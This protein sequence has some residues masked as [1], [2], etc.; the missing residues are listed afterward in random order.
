MSGIFHLGVKKWKL[1]PEQELFDDVI[2]NLNLY[3]K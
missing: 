2:L 1:T 3:G